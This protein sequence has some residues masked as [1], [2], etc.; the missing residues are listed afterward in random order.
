M[1]IEIS[2]ARRDHRVL[3]I[4]LAPA[5]LILKIAVWNL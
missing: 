4:D 3:A 2:I 1:G 5:L